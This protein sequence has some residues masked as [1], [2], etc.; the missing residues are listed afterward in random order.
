MLEERSI[1]T[2]GMSSDS[3]GGVGR[4]SRGEVGLVK[5]IGRRR[6]SREENGQ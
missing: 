6:D 1:G 5:T 2:V 3:R 4:D